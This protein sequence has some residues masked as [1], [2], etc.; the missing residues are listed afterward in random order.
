MLCQRKLAAEGRPL[1]KLKN[2]ELKPWYEAVSRFV[3]AVLVRRDS[4]FTPG[5]PIW[6]DPPLEDFHRRFVLNPDTSSDSFEEKLR[7]QLLGATPPVIQLAGELLFVHFLPGNSTGGDKKRAQI[8]NVLQLAPQPIEI[9]EE[10]GVILDLGV[11]AEGQGFRIFR[12]F[13]LFYLVEFIRKWWTLSDSE[14][15]TGL[16]D[17]WAFKKIAGGVTME[18]SSSQQQILLHLV[19][20]DTFEAMMSRGHKDEIAKTFGLPDE[21]N[22]DVDR[23]LLLIRQRL[24]SKYGEGFSFYR[25]DIASQWMRADEQPPLPHEIANGVRYWKIAPGEG[26]SLWEPCKRS[27]YICIG[28]GELG[29]MREVDEPSFKKQQAKCL[30]KFPDWSERGSN[31]VWKFAKEVKFGHKVAANHG[32]DEVVGLG[33]I[34]GDYF[35]VPNDP[36]PH[37]FPVRWYDTNPRKVRR[38]TAWRSTLVE[39]DQKGFER[40]SE[41]RAAEPEDGSTIEEDDDGGLLLRRKNVVLYGPPGTGKTHAALRLSENWKRWQG[42][43]SVL[44]VTFHPT[45]AYEDFIEGFRPDSAGRFE[46]RSGIF[47]QACELSRR[48][49]HRKFLLVID[50]LNR[51][52]VARVFGELITLIEPDKRYVGASRRLPYSQKDFWVPENLHILGTMNTADRSIS[53]LDIAIRRRFCFVPYDPDPDVIRFSEEHHQKVNGI[54]LAELLEGLN[55]R[56]MESGVDRDRAVGHSHFLI[57]VD[58]EHPLEVL[59]ER[60]AYDIIPLVEE[61]CYSDRSRMRQ[62]LGELVTEEGQVDRNVFYEDDQFTAVLLVLARRGSLIAHTDAEGKT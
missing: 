42:D 49:P 15:S 53:L 55:R 46:L 39:L 20:P 40:I 56:L 30:K 33:E 59:R 17:P 37:R 25:D 1:A 62:V 44:Q 5:E 45:F 48:E 10:L 3:D 7:R 38:Q 23:T 4:I 52:D 51:G 22:E 41:A 19:H 36:Y 57:P 47:V 34:T 54:D 2:A 31:Q 6:S 35:Y 58:A 27:G 9:P 13:N 11:A 26:A 60:F 61:Y 18:R 43:T 8:R 16:R 24:S 14:R 21:R 32:L 29:D 28:W 50:E 12:P